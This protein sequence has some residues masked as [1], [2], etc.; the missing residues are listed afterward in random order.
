MLTVPQRLANRRLFAKIFK[1]QGWEWSQAQL[2]KN[3][4]K[5]HLRSLYLPLKAGTRSLFFKSSVLFGKRIGRLLRKEALLT[6]WLSE[7]SGIAPRFVAK[8]E[9]GLIFWFAWELADHLEGFVC[10]GEM[11]DQLDGERFDQVIT[12]LDRLWSVRYEQLPIWRSRMVMCK[13]NYSRPD[14]FFRQTVL[15]L[16]I[17]RPAQRK[18]KLAWKRDTDQLVIDL[19]AILRE[20]LK[21]QKPG[22]GHLAHGDLAPN[23]LYFLP[24]KAIFLDWEWS[25]WAVNNL[26]GWSL[27]VANFYTRLWRRP[28]LAEAFLT[29]AVKVAEKHFEDVELGVGSAMVFSVLQKI[30]PLYVKEAWKTKEG[31]FHFNWLVGVLEKYARHLVDK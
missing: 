19:L 1:S 11:V 22:I 2:E 3:L 17:L 14:L 29:R 10:E 27:D 31:R 21:Q 25:F 16:K 4:A 23:N 9:T 6:E 28:E 18:P 15:Y 24:E 26:I 13:E 20:R 30:S 5:P 8:G 12:G 7:E